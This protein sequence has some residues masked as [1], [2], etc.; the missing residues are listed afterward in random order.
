M[1]KWEGG[2]E[3]K[4]SFLQHIFLGFQQVIAVLTLWVVDLLGEVF[5]AVLALEGE[6]VDDVVDEIPF[7]V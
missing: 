1:G 5:L 3:G 2:E 4:F 7:L 6:V